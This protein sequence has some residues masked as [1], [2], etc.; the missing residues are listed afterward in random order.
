MKSFREFAKQR[1]MK[2]V[3]SSIIDLDDLS[4]SF[5]ALLFSYG[6]AILSIY[7]DQDAQHVLIIQR[8]RA[9]N[10]YIL[11]KATQECCSHSFITQITNMPDSSEWEGYKIPYIKDI[12]LVR[13]LNNFYG[14]DNEG[15]EFDSDEFRFKDYQVDLSLSC[16]KMSIEMRNESNGYYGGDL[17]IVDDPSQEDDYGSIRNPLFCEITGDSHFPVIDKDY[18]YTKTFKEIIE[19]PRYKRD[20][21]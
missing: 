2:V 16:G 1:L 10:F 7:I 8:S 12:S 15:D 17:I 21:I 4:K 14:K 19:S 9:D 5:F 13:C 11:F 6:G 20:A 18:V 3:D